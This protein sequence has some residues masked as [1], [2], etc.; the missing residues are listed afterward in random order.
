MTESSEYALTKQQLQHYW[1]TKFGEVW[2]S[3]CESCSIIPIFPS[4]VF[5]RYE[6]V[7]AKYVPV[8]NIQL[9]CQDC[10][11]NRI[12]QTHNANSRLNVWLAYF[13]PT[14]T[15]KCFCCHRNTLK[16]FDS[17]HVAH[18]VA[19]SKGGSDKISNLRP[20]CAQ[21]NLT[22]GSSSIEDFQS[23]NH[24]KPILQINSIQK[25]NLHIAQLEVLKAV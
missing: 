11:K 10:V 6:F 22:M 5:V 1:E 4:S 2:A 24:F 8:T 16:Y 18:F 13:G 19:Q 20:V 14:Y 17:W 12:Y 21:C 15:E 3:K 9:C 25:Q 23:L 7:P